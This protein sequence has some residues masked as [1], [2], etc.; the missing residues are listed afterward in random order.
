MRK[1]NDSGTASSSRRTVLSSMS[2]QTR[3]NM[4][5][6]EKEELFYRLGDL[7]AAEIDAENRRLAEK[8]GI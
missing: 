1:R 6:R 7:T 5:R 8:W 2:Y 4:Y 3:Q